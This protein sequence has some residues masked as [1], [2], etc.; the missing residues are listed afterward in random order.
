MGKKVLEASVM[1]AL[2]LGLFVWA[3]GRDAPTATEV[4]SE[5]TRLEASGSADSAALVDLANYAPPEL[6]DDLLVLAGVS[7]S[8]ES[9]QHAY[10]SLMGSC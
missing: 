10:A 4:C 1:L 9:V 7:Y 5:Y 6:A 2:V 3:E 8:R